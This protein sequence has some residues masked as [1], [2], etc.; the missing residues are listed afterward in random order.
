M[1]IPPRKPT[2]R[3]STAAGKRKAVAPKKSSA[4]PATRT[5][6][7]KPAPSFD[8]QMASA[9]GRAPRIPSKKPALDP[10]SFLSLVKSLKAAFGGRHVTFLD[11]PWE[12]R[13]IARSLGGEWIEKLNGY[14]YIGDLLPARLE[15]YASTDY[16]YLRW[17]ED[18]VN[19]RIK[20]SK[21]P[22]DGYY[23]PKPHQVEAI[24]KI[25]ETAAAGWRGF[26]E[27][28]MTGL[29]KSISGLMGASEVASHKGFNA[30]NK[31]KV[32]IIC[33]NGAIAHWKNTIRHL[34]IDNLRIMVVN[35]ESYKK[36][37]TV[38]KAAKEA[39]KQKTKNRHISEKGK[40]YFNWNIIISDESQKLKNVTSQ[41]T[42]A[43]ERIAQYALEAKI[44]PYVIWMSATAG[45]TPLELAYLCP[46]IAQA[47]RTKI[48]METWPE[49]LASNKFNVAKKG[50][51]WQ[52][53][54]PTGPNDAIARERQKQDVERL[55]SILFHP[56]A[57]SIRRKPEDIAGWP[58]VNRIAMPVQLT[59]V[60]RDKYDQLWTE[61][62]KEM[63]LTGMGKNPKG[64]LA[65]QLRFAQK[66]SLLRVAQTVDN[67]ASLVESGEQVA[68]SVR[69]LETLDAI[70]DGLKAQG[71]QCSEYSGRT[72]ID[73]EKERI[74]F[75]K[76]KTQVILFTVEEA[77]SFHAK[78]SLPDGSKASAAARSLLVHD[79]R[80]SALSMTQIIGRT[81]R[82]GQN[83]NAYFLYS[84]NTV[85]ERIMDIMLNKL[86]NM[87]LLSG[88]SEEDGIVQIIQEC[89]S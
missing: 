20:P 44:A 14:V 23:T 2:K 81:H 21:K 73:K 66:A 16:S 54:K 89:L 28:D 84:E 53:V 55:A 5:S 63:N 67:A 36:L 9:A 76:G 1:A 13:D 39:K 4:K 71:I 57:P 32:L 19:G 42:Q 18:Q 50:K 22:V 48:S 40:S 56:K 15:N 83:S 49:W 6:V 31:A 64:I 59:T 68:I 78:E 75:Q 8:A 17:I 7:R 52:W 3:T 37:L 41:R 47:S 62:R 12:E 34:P 65:I 11:V 86:A 46:I 38:P 60:Q 69:F 61:F 79:M 27:A 88:D 51:T 77:V 43:F 25:K 87:T 70:R 72:Y 45:Q 35:Y 26:L 74:E 24:E 85:E 58:P 82:D 30:N 33:P 10:D 29:G 80:Y